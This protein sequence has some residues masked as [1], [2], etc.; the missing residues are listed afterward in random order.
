MVVMLT[1]LGYG[2]VEKLPYKQV[3]DS[4]EL[5][6]NTDNFDAIYA[7]FSTEM[8]SAL[9]IGKKKEF[10]AGLKQQAGKI[11]TRIFINYEQNLCVL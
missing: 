1:N 5:N 8:Q 10:L 2:Q 11:T 6:Y 7:N 4:F 9:P 3:A